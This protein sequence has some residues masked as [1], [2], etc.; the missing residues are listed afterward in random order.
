MLILGGLLHVEED[1]WSIAPDLLI[2]IFPSVLGISFTKDY[3]NYIK[4][5]TFTKRMALYRTM[6]IRIEEVVLARF[7]NI[8]I[9]TIYNTLTLFT[10]LYFLTER[11]NGAL[12]LIPYIGFT[13]T[14]VGYSMI[15]S[16]CYVYYELGYSG[17][18]Y[19]MTNFVMTILL[20]IVVIVAGVLNWS[21]TQHL[22]QGQVQYGPLLPAVSIL[23]GCLTWYAG[24][25]ITIRH[26]YR[27]EFR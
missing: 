12:T 8:I 18:R 27:R 4:N 6:P 3:L 24:Y 13:I 7:L 20:L 16:A 25:H 2:V 26:L 21:I 9:C 11:M 10:V 19:L 1:Q 14:L 15:M 22:I 17:K 5:D 23:I